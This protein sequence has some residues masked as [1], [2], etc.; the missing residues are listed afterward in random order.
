M[1]KRNNILTYISMLALSLCVLVSGVYA[2]K[3]A[4]MASSG[5]VSF[6]AE[7]CIVAITSLTSTGQ[8]SSSTVNTI[9]SSSELRLESKG[10]TT[11]KSHA[12]GTLYFDDVTSSGDT[13]KDI[14]IA[15]VVKNYSSF[16]IKVT[17]K[18]DTS[19]TNYQIITDKTTATTVASNATTTVNVTLK[20]KATNTF[21]AV[22]FSIG[23]SCVKA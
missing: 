8:H 11:S 19:G 13:V 7:N 10:T 2:A 5:K 20:C 9:S 6:T 16:S 1:K 15:I 12:L 3:N 23:I 21:S 18:G 22:N 14:T 4:S 17:S